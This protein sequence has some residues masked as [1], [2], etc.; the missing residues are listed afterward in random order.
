MTA[1][2]LCGLDIREQDDVVVNGDA[3]WH[4]A[5]VEAPTR[6]KRRRIGGW[7]AFGSKGQMAMGDP[8]RQ[9][10]TK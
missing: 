8:Q 2:R 10:P 5:C 4:A 6:T 3:R 1:C 9:T 7:A